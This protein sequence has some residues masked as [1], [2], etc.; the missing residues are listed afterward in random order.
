MR[1]REFLAGLTAAAVARPQLGDNIGAARDLVYQ[2][3]E[4]L[5]ANASDRD[6]ATAIRYLRLAL[7]EYPSF[8]DAHYYRYLCLKRL[9]QDLVM[10]RTHL[11][12]AERYESEAMRDKRDPFVLAVPKI[13]ESLPIVGQKWALVV[14]ISRF[15]PKTGAPSLDFAAN[16]ADSF[17]ELLRD[18]QV[19][20]FPKDQVHTLI[21]NNATTSAIKARLNNIATEA[22]PEDIVVIYVSTHGSPRA[23][24]LRQ[25]SYIYTYDTDISSGDKIFGT[26]LAMVDVSGII[27]TRCV[28]QRT[29]VIF[30]TCHSGSGLAASS[31][32][33]ADMDRL[34]QGAGRYILSSC[35]PD[36]KSYESDGHGYF[37]ASLIEKLRARQGC[38]RL[39][40]LY[41]QVRTDVSRQVREKHN[42]EQRPVMAVSQNSTDIVLGAAVGGA[43]EGCLAG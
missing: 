18:P 6:T 7:D 43:S 9:N 15:Q 30:D 27:N 16:D 31:L 13:Y 3:L 26:A 39:K 12:A 17:A 41:E 24:D 11:Q 33:T 1:R 22:K 10:Q 21:N 32:S 28:A 20:R 40:D 25:V 19:G 2:A 42:K 8:G 36:Q 29:I 37:T 34:R 5:S 23:Q 38:I 14:G 4:L 35:E